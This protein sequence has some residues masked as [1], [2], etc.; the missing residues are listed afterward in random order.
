MNHTPFK[1]YTGYMDDLRQALAD[2]GHLVGVAAGSGITA[3]YA[4]QGGCNLIMALNSGK[5]RSMGCGSMAG[6][7]CYEN[8]NNMV[9]DYAR[10]ELLRFGTDVPVIFGF[11]ATD[12]THRLYDYIME[13]KRI[14]FAGINNYPTV[15]MI[16]GQFCK[17]LR[18][19]GIRFEQEVEAI[20]FANYCGLMT[21][22][23]VFNA[24]QA[25]QMAL[26]NADI[27]CAHFGL[28]SGGYLGPRK[29]LTLESTRRTAM[30]IFDAVDAVNSNIIK[31]VYGGP[32]KTPID[33]QYMYQGSACQGYIGG[34]AFERTPVEHAILEMTQKFIQDAQIV[35]TSK[36]ERILFT[37]PGQYDYVKFIKEYIHEEYMND[38]HLNELARMLHLSTSY[39]ST[40]FKQEMGCNFRDYL[41]GIRMKKAKDLICGAKNYAMI[42]ISQMVGYQDYAQF[43][44]MYKKFH[45]RS[46]MADLQNHKKAQKS[47]RSRENKL[48][49]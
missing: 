7:L 9:M 27:V 48:N 21:V 42:Q 4:I 40:L 26:A 28:T 18:E 24:S 32:I 15:G 41:M 25:E 47:E 2:N 5:Y 23:F 35:P 49:K 20:R 36:L 33:A 14:G 46:P 19:D 16:D 31:M 17:A 8:S 3:K 13:I 1:S 30:E 22:A 45:G 38:I 34:S 10:K 12:P 39:L 6:F 44:K 43:S 29:A 11:N 37:T